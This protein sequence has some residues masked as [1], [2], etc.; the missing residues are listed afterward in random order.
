MPKSALQRLYG[1]LEAALAQHDRM[2]TGKLKKCRK[3]CPEYLQGACPKGDSCFKSRDREVSAKFRRFCSALR[4]G[5]CPEGD[6]CDYSH[7]IGRKYGRLCIEFVAGLCDLG[8]DCACSHDLTLSPADVVNLPSGTLAQHAAIRKTMIPALEA[9]ATSLKPTPCADLVTQLPSARSASSKACGSEGHADTARLAVL[10]A[11]ISP[12]PPLHLPVNSSTSEIT[13]MSEESLPTGSIAVPQ[14]AEFTEAR[15]AVLVR[16]AYRRVRGG[17]SIA[18]LSEQE[19]EAIEARWTAIKAR[20]QAKDELGGLQRKSPWRKLR[21]LERKAQEK[22]RARVR[23]ETDAVVEED[24]EM[25]A[26]CIG[27][28]GA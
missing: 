28:S 22:K 3:L 2:L 23:K 12:R 8:D 4:T 7:A 11:N 20:C 10:A 14:S 6:D 21:K 9:S 26:A 16:I 5:R 15:V 25:R 13:L 1:P 27:S 19:C 24:V 18:Q 17:T